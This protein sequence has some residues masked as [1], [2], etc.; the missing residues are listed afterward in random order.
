MVKVEDFHNDL[1]NKW[2]PGCGNFGI[3]DALKDALATRNIAPHELLMIS[4]IGQAAKT[5][6]FMNCN[7]FHTLHGRSLPIATGAKMANHDLN[8]VVNGLLILITP[9]T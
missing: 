3:L 5:P 6:Q 7:F 2:C 4:G 1:E 8:I 9:E